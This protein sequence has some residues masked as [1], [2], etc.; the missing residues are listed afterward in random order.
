[1]TTL[2]KKEFE[3]KSADNSKVCFVYETQFN[4]IKNAQRIIRENLPEAVSCV[5]YGSCSRSDC[6]YDS[7][8][9]LL[10]LLDDF[11][12]DVQRKGRQLLSEL[13]SNVI[14]KL[15][16]AFCEKNRFNGAKSTY[17]NSIKRGGIVLW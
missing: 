15:D 14:V 6:K 2:K 10:V 13:N 4:A 16:V 11:S 1:M 17:Y 9:D 7:D 5:L 3:I 8:V 12:C